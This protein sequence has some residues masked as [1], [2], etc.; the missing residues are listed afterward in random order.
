MIGNLTCDDG[1]IAV[2]AADDGRWDGEFFACA[3]FTIIIASSLVAVFVLIADGNG[4]F[5]CGRDVFFGVC[6]D[7]FDIAASNLPLY[8]INVCRKTRNFWRNDG[9]LVTIIMCFVDGW[10]S[11]D[12]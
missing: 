6:N 1:N 12:T 7:T 8:D 9:E 2:V 11:L 10:W 4:V 5:W 3:V